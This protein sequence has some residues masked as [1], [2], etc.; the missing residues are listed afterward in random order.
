MRFT[1][2]FQMNKAK[3]LLIERK[4]GGTQGRGGRNR[5]GARKERKERRA[6]CAWY[7]VQNN[8]PKSQKQTGC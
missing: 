7:T 6:L 3:D 8:E 1:S 2:L 5:E 4:K